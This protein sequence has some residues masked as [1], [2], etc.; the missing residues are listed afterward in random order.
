MIGLFILLLACLW[1]LS[2]VILGFK[3][4]KWLGLTRYRII[5]SILLSLLIFIAPVTDEVIAYPQVMALCAQVK[6]YEYDEAATKGKVISK[7][8]SRPS[9]ESRV[10]F[11]GIRIVVSEY[12]HLELV[13]NQPVIR[14]HEIETRGGMLGFPA[15]S[16]GDKMSVLLPSRCTTV[17]TGAE[18]HQRLIKSLQL[19]LSDQQPTNEKP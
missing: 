8:V 13:T 19:V 16:S 2:A 5:S 1:L 18:N 4:P 6:K 17:P 11:P 10:I 15:G 9:Q 14:W 3:I 12:A 7:Y